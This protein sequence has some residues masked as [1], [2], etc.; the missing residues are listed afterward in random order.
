MS[1]WS[2]TQWK[3]QQAS[4][5]YTAP[6]EHELIAAV[7]GKVIV[8][9]DI[10]VTQDDVDVTNQAHTIKLLSGTGGTQFG[11][12]VGFGV[13]QRTVQLRDLGWRATKSLGVFA[14]FASSQAGGN[15]FIWVA[16]H[17]EK[18]GAA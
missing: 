15:S 14:D 6:A 17:T 1:W 5:A 3:D 9:D 12:T 2:R 10:V 16:Y 11:G 13:Q 18:P 4:H 8:I 7:P